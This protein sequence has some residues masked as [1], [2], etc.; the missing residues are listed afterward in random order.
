MQGDSSPFVN[1]CSEGNTIEGM[2][3]SE[4][5]VVTQSALLQLGQTEEQVAA[6][7]SLLSAVL[8]LSQ[9]RLEGR[10]D[11]A[12]KAEIVA[13]TQADVD[14]AAEGLGLA[15]SVLE[16]ALIS[17]QM[18]TR[19]G[20][21]V[22]AVMLTPD[23]AKGVLEGLAKGLYMR[24]FDHLVR[25]INESTQAPK[26]SPADGAAAGGDG[27]AAERYRHI[28][29]L[30]I[31]GF[32][33][34]VHNS[35]EQLCINYANEKLQQKFTADMFKS[36]QDEYQAEGLQWDAIPFEDN[37][38]VLELIEGSMGLL[39]LLNEECLRPGGSDESYAS[40]I[41][42]M[43]GVPKPGAKKG[44]KPLLKGERL[45]RDKFTLTHYAAPV[46]YS[47]KGFC[48]KNKDSLAE[49]ML[50]AL[51]K[52]SVPFVRGLFPS[53]AAAAAAK[54]HAAAAAGAAA[55]KAPA[56]AKRTH[57]SSLAVNT[58]GTQFKQ[59]LAHLMASINKTRVQ[60]V[61]CIKPNPQK[62]RE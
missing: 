3:D 34:F 6:V 37:A 8:S 33:L 28:G 40:K 23:D 35:F 36:S 27:G 59:Q 47:A 42:Q 49:D 56:R 7:Y 54:A 57:R 25:R 44:E 16:L 48:E 58:V 22:T 45:G 30:D 43:Y 19:G 32:E 26:A 51:E 24:L 11:D 52:A 9:V 18:V 38:G 17:R 41:V 55:G 46:T 62:V 39:A 31:F 4:R 1:P 13:A 53:A 10:P 2:P 5:L 61:R 14:A 29:L 15:G 21:S 60:F 12:D 50:K 20:Q